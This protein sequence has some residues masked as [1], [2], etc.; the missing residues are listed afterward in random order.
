MTR[1]NIKLHIFSNCWYD[2]HYLYEPPAA[3]QHY[4]ADNKVGTKYQCSLY[5]KGTLLWNELPKD[6]Q[7]AGDVYEFKKLVKRRYR[8]YENLL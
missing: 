4:I 2:V 5:Y 1:Y 8:K 3:I 7:F 6:I